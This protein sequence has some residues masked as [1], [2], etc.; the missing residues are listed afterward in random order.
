MEVIFW[1]RFIIGAC[2]IA[3]GLGIFF[4]EIFGLFKFKYV[5]N[6]MHAAAM[7]DTL[8]LGSMILGLIV[9]NGVNFVSLKLFCVILFLWIASPVASHLMAQM[10]VE[11]NKDLNEYEE[12][13]NV[14]VLEEDKEGG[15]ANA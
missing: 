12:I 7:G 10:E 3:M 2:L 8:G 14:S 15:K 11:T 6:R 4:V 13:E 5:L 9:I 1:I